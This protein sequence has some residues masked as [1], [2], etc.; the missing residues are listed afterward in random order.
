MDH[1]DWA[2]RHMNEDLERIDGCCDRIKK[3]YHCYLEEMRTVYDSRENTWYQRW[4]EADTR[5]AEVKTLVEEQGDC[6]KKL[7]KIVG[8]KPKSFSL[9][10]S[11]SLRC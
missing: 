10:S 11:L 9:C 6:I 3:E 1:F 7:E 8:K 4:R 5:M 2:G